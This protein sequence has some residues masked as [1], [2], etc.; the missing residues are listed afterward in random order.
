M[1]FAL[2]TCVKIGLECA[3]SI[4]AS[5][6]KL[7]LLITL[8]DSKASLKSGRVNFDEFCETNSINLK[9]IIHINDLETT[10]YIKDHN[11]DWL[12]IIGWSQIAN[13]K[14]LNAPNLGAIGAHPTLLPEGRGRASIP[15]AI[16]KG[17]KKTGVTFFKIDSGVDTGPI[18]EQESII[19]DK[20]ETASSLYEKVYKTHANIIF[21][22]I[23]KLKNG[24]YTLTT[25]NSNKAS[26]WPGRKP[27]DGKIDLNGSVHYAAK[28]IRATTRPYPG[29]FIIKGNKKI[30]IWSA[31]IVEKINNNRPEEFLTFY[32]GILEFKE[33]SNLEI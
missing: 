3:K 7:K 8:E 19:I 9:K 2:I 17:L 29:A 6:N 13:E 27:E 14:I 16:I 24:S 31:N 15:W 32:D 26:Y 23:K 5:G 33:I 12:F 4:Y 20:N 10:K 1:N 18:F 21:D 30:I 11:I 25:Q 22:L 28:L